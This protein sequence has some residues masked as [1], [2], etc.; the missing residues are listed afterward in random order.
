MRRFIIKGKD[1]FMNNNLKK[2][3]VFLLAFI[4]SFS[5]I[6]PTFAE[7]IPNSNYLYSVVNLSNGKTVGL[8]RV[9]EEI[10]S[11][12]PY[13]K[14]IAKVETKYGTAYYVDRFHNSTMQ[15]KTNWDTL[16]VV[17][18]GESWAEFF[19]EPSFANFAWAALD[20]VALLPELP[21]SAYFRKGG[22]LLLNVDEVKKIS[23]TSDGLSK[24]KK[25]LKTTDALSKIKALAKNYKLNNSVYRDHILKLHSFYSKEKNKSKFVKNFDI[26]RAIKKT[27]TSSAS[28]IS[29]N[30]N[31]RKGYIFIKNFNKKIG[32]DGSRSLKKMKVVIDE[33]GNVVT[34]YPIK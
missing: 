4:I 7:S 12:F 18:A 21:S 19:G 11:I 32:T 2:L 8:K 23:K 26:K 22:K 28:K 5:N 29:N 10:K 3:F 14:I 27:L 9:N 1:L 17:M 34:A 25:A 20:T 6:F 33:L 31:G 13:G 16:D 24:I 30:T 15:S